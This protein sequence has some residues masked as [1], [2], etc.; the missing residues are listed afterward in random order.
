[1]TRDVVES[2][3]RPTGITK[4][5]IDFECETLLLGLQNYLRGQT[6]QNH[7]FGAYINFDVFR[8][9]FEIATPADICGYKAYQRSDFDG[10][11]LPVWWDRIVNKA[12]QHCDFDVTVIYL[13][14]RAA[15]LITG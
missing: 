12:Y 9:L 8:K 3:D 13:S 14:A 15:I 10:A 11:D 7:P 4:E 6:A 1:M 5:R 2:H